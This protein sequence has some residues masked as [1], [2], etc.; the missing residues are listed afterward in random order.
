MIKMI[1]TKKN[2]TKDVI[3]VIKIMQ[4][5]YY[6]TITVEICGEK[7]AY[8]FFR[9]ENQEK[10]EH[11]KRLLALGYFEVCWEEDINTKRRYLDE[12]IPRIRIQNMN[13]KKG[14]FYGEYNYQKE[15]FTDADEFIESIKNAKTE[16]VIDI[17][18]VPILNHNV[19]KESKIVEMIKAAGAPMY[20]IDC[21]FIVFLKSDFRK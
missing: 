8:E 12:S 1:E 6:K 11:L 5:N 4:A 14:D 3:E 21:T 7:Y 13:F 10:R 16:L 15:K 19:E 2:K 18:N 17:D 9:F 20:R